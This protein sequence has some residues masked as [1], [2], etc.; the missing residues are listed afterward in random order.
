MSESAVGAGVGG[1]G[2]VG[3]VRVQ[4]R[5]PVGSV[6]ALGWLMAELFDA[7]R[8]E[9]VTVRQP[10]FNGTVQLPLVAEL[11]QADRHRF[12][13]SLLHDLLVPFP[14]LSHEAVKAASAAVAAHASLYKAE[15]RALHLS[16][17]DRLADDQEQLSAYQLGLAL[18]DMCWVPSK[19][20]GPDDFIAMFSR[21]QIAA[22]KGLLDGAGAAIPPDSAA[23]VGKSLENWQEWVDVNAPKMKLGTVA[24]WTRD[25]NPVL[26]ALRMQGAAWHSVLIA[27]PDVTVQPAL[28]AWAHAASAAARAARVVTFTILRRFWPVVVLMAAALGGLLYLVISTLS[29]TGEVWASLVTVATFVGGGTLGVGSGVS[30]AFSGVSYEA[31]SA[32]KLEAQAWNITWLP[33]TAQTPTERMQLDT[34]GVAAPQFRKNLDG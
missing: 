9:S 8:Q 33:A 32:A 15:L 5:P 14:S 4:V 31:W 12:L 22:L 29:G 11:D 27:D 30:A 1:L 17:L 21:G 28:A 24:A 34:R 7:Q 18:S 6:Y 23:V 16:L 2:G 13:M 20:G 3:G 10:P 25:A 26:H 19:G